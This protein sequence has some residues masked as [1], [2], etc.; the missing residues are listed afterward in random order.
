LNQQQ[1]LVHSIMTMYHPVSVPAGDLRPQHQPVVTPP[2]TLGRVKRLQQGYAELRDDLLEE[3]GSIEYRVIK[4]AQ[5]AREALQPMRKFIKKR[6]ERKI[7]LQRYQGR[8][9]A[10]AKMNNRSEREEA[11]LIKHQSDI[12]RSK[13]VCA[14]SASQSPLSIP[15]TGGSLAESEPRHG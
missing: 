2:A 6:Q 4:P 15:S 11:A 9:E 1:F 7:D 3:M 13:D 14:I 10:V 12:E 8:Y 5:D